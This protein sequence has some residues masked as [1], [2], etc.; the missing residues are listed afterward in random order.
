V[1]PRA[2]ATV[3]RTV[4]G[5]FGPRRGGRAAASL[6][7][8][9]GPDAFF[10]TALADGRWYRSPRA[11]PGAVVALRASA[12]LSAGPDPQRFYA[13]GV[14]TWLNPTFGSLPVEGP[15]DFVFA[16][17]VLPLRGFGYNEAAGDRVALV[18]AEARLPLLAA[19]VPG[20]LPLPALTALQAAA[21]VDA[22]VIAQG[23]LDVW[24]TPTDSAGVAL[25]RVLDDVLIGA[26]AGLRTVVLGYP[27]RVDWAAPFDGRRFRDARVYVSVGRD[28]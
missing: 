12:G 16:T 27:L 5:R 26:G 24:R 10:A 14:Q 23:G 19:L 17:P 3:D 1:V 25:P 4:A 11:V 9:V 20:G 7:V 22:G 8:A 28:F 15:D 18:N 2:T 13:A 21:F 6:A